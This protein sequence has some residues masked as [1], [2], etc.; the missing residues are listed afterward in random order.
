MKEN[1]WLDSWHKGQ[2]LAG[3]LFLGSHYA[4]IIAKAKTAAVFG[5]LIDRGIKP[6]D[7]AAIIDEVNNAD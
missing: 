6:E 2:E 4:D 7:I 3:E 5:K 1:D